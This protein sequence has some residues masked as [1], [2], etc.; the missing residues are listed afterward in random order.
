[1]REIR[2]SGS[3]GGGAESNR[4]SLPLS[5]KLWP[6]RRLKFKNHAAE[7]GGVYPLARSIAAIESRANLFWSRRVTGYPSFASS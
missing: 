6:G 4:L 2:Q 5:G 1:M 7:A 3:E